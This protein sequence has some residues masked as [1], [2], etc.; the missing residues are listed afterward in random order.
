MPR[1]FELNENYRASQLAPAGTV[2]VRRAETYGLKA[3]FATW[4]PCCSAEVRVNASVW[5]QTG[6][7]VTCKSCRWK[8]EVFLA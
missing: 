4:S 2:V 6:A 3:R 7:H 8:W 5:A 1:R